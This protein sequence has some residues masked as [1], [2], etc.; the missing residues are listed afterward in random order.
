[1]ARAK[2]ETVTLVIE[3]NTVVVLSD[4]EYSGE[5][6]VNA[7]TAEALKQTGKV[8]DYVESADA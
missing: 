1:M 3:D 8:K 5:V 6:T 2:D 4:L 7:A